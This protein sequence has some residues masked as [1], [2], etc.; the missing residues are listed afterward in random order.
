MKVSSVTF[1]QSVKIGKKQFNTIYKTNE[2]HMRDL[3]VE[4][5]PTHGLIK[6]SSKD[7]QPV[8]VGLANVRCFQSDEDPTAKQ[9]EDRILSH[10]SVGINAPSSVAPEGIRSEADLLLEK[11]EQTSIVDKKPEDMTV[12]DQRVYYFAALQRLGVNPH[13]MTKVPKLKEK[14][15]AAME[16]KGK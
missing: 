1:Y 2:S 4:F 6:V 8:F 3:I 7:T 5:I 9:T 11:E 14:L 16:A 13:P 15:K 12:E 10:E